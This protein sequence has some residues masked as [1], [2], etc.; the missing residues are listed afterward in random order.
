MASSFSAPAIDLSKLPAPDFLAAIDFDAEL[1]A[2]KDDLAARAPELEQILSLES[3]PLVK[4]L[5]SFAYRMM[6]KTIQ[7]NDQTKNNL[8]AFAVGAQLD[9]IGVTYHRTERLIIQVA[10][11]TANPPV[12]EVL[13]NDEDYRR[14]IQLAPEGFTT[15]GP[16]G[17]YKFHALSAASAVKDAS[18]TNPAAGIVLV[19]ILSRDGDGA[20]NAELLAM[21]NAAL[22]DEDVRPLTDHVQIAPANII[23]YQID[24][25]LTLLQGP[26]S[27]LVIGAANEAV[28]SY[29]DEQHILGY[30]I[31][32]SGIYAALHQEGVQN[33]TLRSPVSDIIIDEVSAAY[34]DTINIIFGGRDE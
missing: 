34:C 13:E 10:D 19:T 12:A 25:T 20:P 32:L 7:Y 17:A 14:R 26:D 1:S 6:V 27:S 3:E 15:A 16:I 11:D 30:D 28:R 29:V 31:T 4:L 8:L 22:N 21:V 9:H 2:L 33:V 24:A 5:E 18:V 23:R